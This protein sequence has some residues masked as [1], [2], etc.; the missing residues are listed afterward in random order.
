MVPVHSP[1][2]NQAVIWQEPEPPSKKP[3]IVGQ[4]TGINA[5]YLEPIQL[6]LSLC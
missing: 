3:M 5:G 6:A 1:N 4:S 2:L